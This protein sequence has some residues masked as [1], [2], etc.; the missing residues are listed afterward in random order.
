LLHLVSLSA[1]ALATI[2]LITPAAWHRVVERGRATER[3]YRLASALVLAALVPL[4]L[5]LAGD[6]YLVAEKVTSSR[7]I[8]GWLSG[9]CIAVF[10]VLWF[11][12][13]LVRRWRSGASSPHRKCAK[14]AP[15]R[16]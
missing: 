8:A 13:G 3:F 10:S 1:I 16:S 7:S 14:P 2:L 15:P 12:V 4:A 9:G 6:L 11:G 5:G